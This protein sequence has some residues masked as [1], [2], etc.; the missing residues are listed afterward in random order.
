M[1]TSMNYVQR[2]LTAR[3]EVQAAFIATLNLLSIFDVI[4]IT[5]DQLGASNIA[6]VAWFGVASKVAFGK[7]IDA[8]QSR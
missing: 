7:D 5:D 8:L 6:L 4:N 3:P 2:I 1:L